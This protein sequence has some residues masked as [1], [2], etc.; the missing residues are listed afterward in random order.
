MTEANRI[1]E[2]E[3]ELMSQR[4]LLDTLNTALTEANAT[5]DQLQKRTQRLERQVSEL[6]SIIQEPPPNERPP[7][8]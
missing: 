1:V 6:T 5:I 2:L 8:Y 3:L 7:H 4:E